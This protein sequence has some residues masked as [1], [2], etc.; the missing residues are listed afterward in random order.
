MHVGGILAVVLTAL[1]TPSLAQTPFRAQ[2][3]YAYTH[4]A[5]GRQV[6]FSPDSRVLAS[7]SADGTIQLRSIPDRRVLRI[8]RSTPLTSIAFSPDGELIVSGGYDGMLRIWCVADGALVRALKAS[9]ETVWAVDFS[10]DGRS[11]ASS[12]DDKKARI[13]RVAD[14]TLLHTLTGHTLNVWYVRFSPDG[15]YVATS[16]FDHAIKIWRASDGALV[17]TLTG[18][19]QAVVGFA[20]SPD[21]KTLAS[22]SDDSSVRIWRVEDGRMLR[23]IDAGNHV[24][25]VAYTPDGKYIAG[26]G[27]ERGFVGTFWRKIAP[28]LSGRDRTTVRVWRVADGSLVLE[29]APHAGNA[30]DVAI[31]ADG[32]WLAT[33]GDEGRGTVW[34]VAH[35]W[36]VP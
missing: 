20:F 4:A 36:I 15:S 35:K 31:S 10:P 23:S 16:S 5:A 30:S 17:R 1:T 3:Q 6:A 2:F 27:R 28:R 12:G 14:G 21:G 26:A 11:V 9:T 8:I 19:K 29:L 13:W 25:H 22:G 18:H 7:S 34:R 24:Y 33:S 32:Q